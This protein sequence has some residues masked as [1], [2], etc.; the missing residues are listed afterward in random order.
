MVG[1]DVAGSEVHERQEGVALVCTSANGWGL[2][3]HGLLYPP[4]ADVA[5][6]LTPLIAERLACGEPV[7]AALS[8]KVV[9]QL[10]NRLATT[11]GLH[12]TDVGGLYRYPGRVL[13]HY[14]DWIA[15]TSP[16]GAATIVA[17]PQLDNDNPHRA[18]LWMQ[19]DA[20]TT[21]ALSAC[22]LTLV[23]ACPNDPAT[24]TVIRHAH[25]SLLN[26]TAT[27]NP[28]HLPADQFL[29]N[30]PLPPPSELGQSDAIHVLDHPRQLTELRQVVRS[31][32][33]RAGLTT[34]RS[35]DLV[36]AVSEVASNALE[37]G[38][39]PATVCLWITSTLV[40]CQISDNGHF[41]QPLAGLL[42]PHRNQG[43]GRGLWMI[44]QLCDEL[45]RWPHP[46]TI[47]LHID[48]PQA[49]TP[50]RKAARNATSNL[51]PEPHASSTRQWNSRFTR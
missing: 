27:A 2:A 16:N 12:T 46:T 24:A 29:A 18:A 45:Y 30:H 22:D 35:E 7:L 20:L 28:D 38:V 10:R 43:R 6:I 19:V 40:I 9:A 5:D 4:S 37:H 49:T 14:L 47:R 34:S 21:Q 50:D 11:A 8:P 51:K 44:H 17:A 15:G 1:L 41:T 31:H 42:P 39:P 13:G 32:A 26:G 23:C 36:L 25:P 33:A 48:R 3:H